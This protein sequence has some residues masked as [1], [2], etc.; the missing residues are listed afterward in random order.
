M[1][2]QHPGRRSFLLQA[3]ALAALPR[4]AV[5][6]EPAPVRIGLTPVFLDDQVS[7]LTQWRAWLEAKLGRSISFV[8]RGN[9]REVVDLVRGGKIDFAWLCGYPYVRYR[10]ELK[11]VAVPLWRG[12]P[13]YQSYLI[14]PADDSRSR[15]LL[16]L[17]GRIFA[18]SDPDSNSGFLYPRYLLTTQGE[19]PASFFSRTF[20][21]WAH[22]KVVEVVGAAL[23]NGGAVDGYVWEALAVSNP[24]LTGA[25]RIIERS[26]PLGHP[27]IVARPDIPAADLERFRS[28]LLT[29]AQDARGAELLGQLHLDGFVAGSPALYDDIARMARVV[30]AL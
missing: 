14:V 8:Q 20:F 1:P 9:Y 2:I 6:A 5:C 26:G 18:Y 13:L 11:L 27:P 28:A 10:R 17:K 29:M 21:T 23:A 30:K 7:F 22:R 15:S 3:A 25:T 4:A 19:N 24:Q 12:Q 16:D